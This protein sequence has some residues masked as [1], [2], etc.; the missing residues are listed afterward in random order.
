[1]T[2]VAL[3][4]VVAPRSIA[5][6]VMLLVDVKFFS[7]EEW[8]SEKTAA[9]GEYAISHVSSKLSVRFGKIIGN[10]I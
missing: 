4:N 10:F 1:M 5:E 6:K 7:F 9:G 8:I 3:P 2:K